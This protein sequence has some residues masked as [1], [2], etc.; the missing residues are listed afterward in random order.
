MRVGDLLRRGGLLVDGVHRRIRG[1]QQPRQVADQASSQEPAYR[2]KE[3]TGE[4]VRKVRSG[5]GLRSEDGPAE[6][7]RRKR[8]TV[9]VVAAGAVPTHVQL[10]LAIE[11]DGSRRKRGPRTLQERS[12]ITLS[13]LAAS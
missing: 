9:V 5:K 7:D 10:R 4:Q 8:H 3:V 11:V 1:S 12:S 6:G 2:L 13:W